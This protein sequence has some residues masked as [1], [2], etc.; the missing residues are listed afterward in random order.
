MLAHIGLLL[1]LLVPLC[2]SQG[3]ELINPTSDSQFQCLLKGPNCMG[4]IPFWVRVGKADGTIDQVG[5]QNLI[6]IEKSNFLRKK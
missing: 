6:S 5:I 4:M 1:A 2:R 3:Y